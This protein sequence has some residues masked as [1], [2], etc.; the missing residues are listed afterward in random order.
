MQ[1]RD[2]QAVLLGQWV[3]LLED[4]QRDVPGWA[5]ADPHA[6]RYLV[7]PPSWLPKQQAGLLDLSLVV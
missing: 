4:S 2:L 3:T 1:A 6:A 7:E 5:V